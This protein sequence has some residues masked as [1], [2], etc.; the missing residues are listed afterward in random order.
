MHAEHNTQGILLPKVEIKYYNAVIDGQNVFD[1]PVKKDLK[2]MITFRI[3]RE[4]KEMTTQLV[5]Y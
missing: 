3:L 2:H 5:V 4:I 1:Q